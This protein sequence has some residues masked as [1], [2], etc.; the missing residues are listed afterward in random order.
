VSDR[1][2]EFWR[3][4]ALFAGETVFVVG[5]GPSL[6]GFDF[7]CL[8]GR[9]VIAVN[10]SGFDVPWADVLVFHDYEWFAHPANRQLIDAWSGL[11]VTFSRRAKAAAPD[12]VRRVDC[13]HRPS[14]PL[15][16]VPIRVG[17]CS[18]QSAVSLA[19][20]MRAKRVVLLGFDMRA[21][22]KGQTHYHKDRPLYDAAHAA[23]TAPVY[24]ESF[25][26][27]W[28]GWHADAHSVGCDVVNATPGS[29][30]TEFP[31]VDLEQE[32]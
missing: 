19:I 22:A 11:V 5:G 27:A 13:I 12:R 3:P 15:A 21:N 4:E 9:R 2:H 16:H 24:A 1:G 26:P 7:R 30:L 17:H 32:L 29:A 23:K 25:L 14:F 10:A 8:R 18:G 6:R 31:A 20:T 28:K